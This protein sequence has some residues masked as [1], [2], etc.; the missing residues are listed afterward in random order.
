MDRR[1]LEAAMVFKVFSDPHRLAILSLLS[2][3]ELCACVL[4]EAL[5]ISQPTLSHHMKIL[6]EAGLVK[7]RPE[8]KWVHYGINPEGIELARAFLDDI[9]SGASRKGRKKAI[10]SALHMPTAACKMTG[11]CS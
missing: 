9:A 11:A 10:N 6:R 1:I 8:G 3:Q 2:G 7:E 4:L 5:D